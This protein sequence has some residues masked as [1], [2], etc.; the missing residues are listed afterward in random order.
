MN[1]ILAYL[2]FAMNE[3]IY[4]MFGVDEDYD[5]YVQGA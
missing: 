1:A 4:E 2:D 3:A 5:A